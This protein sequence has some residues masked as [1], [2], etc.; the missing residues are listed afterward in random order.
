MNRQMPYSIGTARE[1]ADVR[2]VA[3]YEPDTG[4]IVHMH[5]VTVFKGGRPVSEAEA[6]DAAHKQATRI[7]LAITRLEAKV[8]ATLETAARP[9]RI[10]PKTHEFV[11]LPFPEFGILPMKL[12]R[13]P[14]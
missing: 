8:T 13:P 4:K 2:I 14:K 12:Q 10:D 1:A 7:G 6:I 5:A 3:L 11:P 9:H